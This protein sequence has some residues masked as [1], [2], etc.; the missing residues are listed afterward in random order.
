M[1]VILQESLIITNTFKVPIK[2]M[3]V[4]NSGNPE[5]KLTSPNA[6]GPA[7]PHTFQKPIVLQPGEQVNYASVELDL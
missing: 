2:L 7:V 6:Q 4:V 1:P 3:G 5:L